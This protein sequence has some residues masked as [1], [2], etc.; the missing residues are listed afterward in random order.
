MRVRNFIFVILCFLSQLAFGQPSVTNNKA[1]IIG[2]D[3]GSDSQLVMIR[4]TGIIGYAVAIKTFV[5]NEST[6]KLKNNRYTKQTLSSKENTLFY[7]FYGQKKNKKAKSICIDAK[8][9]ETTY[10]LFFLEPKLFT[11]N[12][13]AVQISK[14]DAERYLLDVK[15]DRK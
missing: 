10:V 2:N 11:N 8:P 3:Q 14:A 7:Q 4:K 5:N 12:F 6:R 9:G 13:H 15:E 1:E